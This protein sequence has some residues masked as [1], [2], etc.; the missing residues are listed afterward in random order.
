MF[1]QDTNSGNTLRYASSNIVMNIEETHFDGKV[2]IELFNAKTNKVVVNIGKAPK[3][4]ITKLF[5]FDKGA[6]T[7]QIFQNQLYRHYDE[8]A[9]IVLAS[10]FFQEQ[11]GNCLRWTELCYY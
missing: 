4:Q 2:E 9:L 10:R 11:I 5:L 6:R 8:F 7:N 1:P 3:N